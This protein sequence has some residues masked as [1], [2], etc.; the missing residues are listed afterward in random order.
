MKIPINR[1]NQHFPTIN[2]TQFLNLFNAQVSTIY[3]ENSNSRKKVIPL[4]LPSTSNSEL[5]IY[6]DFDAWFRSY[7][8]ISQDNSRIL[9]YKPNHTNLEDSLISI[10]SWT[11]PKFQ[12][13]IVDS[14]PSFYQLLS[15]KD[16]THASELLFYYLS[17]LKNFV[18]TTNAKMILL[19][20]SL[21][22]TFSK[23]NNKF[24]SMKVL[25]KISDNI[26]YINSINNT[27]NLHIYNNNLTI[28]KSVKLKN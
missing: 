14:I 13:L 20:F 25:N 27:T 3:M 28:E 22:K 5:L 24:T 4:F 19:N 16:P 17:S 1:D 15:K 9:L 23:S 10:L 2:N 11:N 12:F 18:H 6:L 8:S 21:Y 7:L 26:I